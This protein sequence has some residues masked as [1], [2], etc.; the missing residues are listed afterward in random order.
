MG[1]KFWVALHRY[2]GLGMLVLLLVNALS[3][4]VLAFQHELDAWLNPGLLRVSHRMS[5]LS[6]DKLVLRVEGGDPRLRVSQLP[7]DTR[8]GE[9]AELRV[10]ARVDPATGRTHVLD[11]DRLFVDPATGEVLGHRQWGALRIDRVHLLTFLDVLH[12]KFHLPGAWGMWLTGGL[13]LAWLAAT[14]LGSWLT[15]PRLAVWRHG[16][17]SKWRAAWTVKRGASISRLVFDLHRSVGLWSLPAAVLLAVSGV[18]FSLGDTVFK[19][20]VSWFSQV[21]VHPLQSL[22]RLSSSPRFAAFGT[23]EAVRHA[24]HHLITPAQDFLP[25]YAS[26]VPSQGVYRIAFKEVGMR[27]TAWRLRYELVFIDDQTGALRASSGYDSGTPGDK[28]LIWQYPLHTGR[29]LGWPGRVAVCVAGL[30]VAF[31]A[32][33]GIWIWWQRS[34]ARRGKSTR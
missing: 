33:T 18:Y 14:L 3:G 30:A 22:P 4:S 15:L 8:P 31:I 32:L 34:R 28:L 25:W 5:A 7:L 16:F 26:H 27:E 9:A 1:R 20:V 11:F 6:P 19:P 2:L 29:I 12:R 21:S 17:W 23:E 13:A 24:R 10:A